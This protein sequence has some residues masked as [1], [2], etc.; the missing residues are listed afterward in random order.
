LVTPVGVELHFW[1]HLLGWSY[2]F[3]HTCWGG[4]TL[5]VTP[6]GVAAKGADVVLHPLQRHH[7][8][9]VPEANIQ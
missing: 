7:H 4:D 2:T 3:G 5:L 8:V 9:V 1:S 6:V